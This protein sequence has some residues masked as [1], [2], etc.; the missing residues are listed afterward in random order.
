[1]RIAFYSHQVELIQFTTF[2]HDITWADHVCASG[3]IY[4]IV[5][6]PQTHGSWLIKLAR[7]DNNALLTSACLL[8]AHLIPL[9]L[10][11]A[12]AHLPARYHLDARFAR[13]ISNEGNLDLQPPA[14][15]RCMRSVHGSGQSVR[16]RPPRIKHRPFFAILPRR[17]SSS[18][19][20]VQVNVNVEIFQ[21]TI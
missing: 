6:T 5:C 21:S 15:V 7:N 14:E 3:W 19:V 11:H 1:M 9:L 16:L 8:E 4:N 2:F 13:T 12:E 18:C 10:V 17:L 20:Q